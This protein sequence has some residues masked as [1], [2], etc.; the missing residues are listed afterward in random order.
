MTDRFEGLGVDVNR[1]WRNDRRPGSDLAHGDPADRPVSVRRQNN[2]L[3]SESSEEEENDYF[4]TEHV[5]YGGKCCHKGF[6][7]GYDRRD[8]R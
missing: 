8:G 3:F 4:E 7:R 1:N 2:P 5:D 6:H